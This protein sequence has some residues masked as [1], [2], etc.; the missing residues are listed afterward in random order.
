[1]SIIYNVSLNQDQQALRTAAEWDGKRWINRTITRDEGKAIFGA[2]W[3]KASSP[4]LVRTD[5]S[6]GMTAN[7]GVGSA[8]VINNFDV[9]PIWGEIEEVQDTLGNVFMRI[10]KCYIKKVDAP[11]FLSW[12][13][14]KHRHPGFYLPWC[15]WDFTNGR[16]LAFVDVGKYKGSSEVIA[17]TTRLRSVPNVAPL[18][19]TTIV[20]MRTF[21]QNNNVSGLNG[22]QQLD[23]HVV[24]LLQTLFYIEFA[25]L[26][27][28]AIM[29]G[30]SIGPYSAAH[31]ATVAETAVNRI[32]V[33][34]AHADLFR[35]GQ[36]IS[37]GTSLG[38]NQIFYGRRITAITVFDASNRAISF[39][40]AP[41]NIAVGNIVYNTGAINGF[42]LGAISATSGTP[43]AND[44]RFPMM[45]RGIESLY[46]N[47]W[48]FVDG[49]NIN[50]RQAWIATN[51]AQYASNVFASPYTMLGYVNSA[52]DG[53]VTAMGF[54]SFNPFANLP[55]AVGGGTTT[56]YSDHYGQA[57]GQRIAFFGGVWTF[58]SALGVSCWNL[59]GSSASAV[60]ALGG[61]L[62][63]KPL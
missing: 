9:A 44:G 14:S 11:G 17:T 35:V 38:G 19:N 4:T 2:R 45:Y 61:R 41:V 18:I 39:D 42:S 6:V 56:F 10:P 57:A 23:I 32:I 47:T 29:Q 59:D 34:N 20:N 7:A 58:G 22:Y 5:E 30:L 62:L 33:A 50:E 27:S 48:Q 31:T 55:V 53:W 46:G 40:G 54:D 8:S 52:T 26:H 3:D 12:Q 21:A 25:T 51:A 49:I 15:F 43:V 16:E 63:K 60:V 13:V 1:M 37:I 28:Q 36:T 24:D